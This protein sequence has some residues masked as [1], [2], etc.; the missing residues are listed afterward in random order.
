VVGVD[1]LP[2]RLRD[3]KRRCA[4]GV[5]LSCGNGAALALPSG[6]FDIVLQVT[7]FTS[8]LDT[9]LR[10]RVALE[11]L[12]VLKPDG[13]IVWYDF[14]VNNPWNPNVRGVG[15]QEIRD[16][17]PNCAVKLQRITLVPPLTRVLA[18]WSWLLC[19]LLERISL[20]CTHYLGVIRKR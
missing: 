9:E 10:R 1:L 7:V 16:L 17:F 12:R 20:F 13:L 8:I 15:R 5:K 4:R 3:A 14:H 18:P 11:M 19:V 2:S 6:W